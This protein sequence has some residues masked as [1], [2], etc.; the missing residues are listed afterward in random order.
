MIGLL[1]KIYNVYT[2]KIAKLRAF[3]WSTFLKKCGKNVYIK[4]GCKFF[5]PKGIEI[6]DHTLIGDNA[7]I[8]GKF[9]VKIGSFVSF[10]G[11]IDVFTVRNSYEDWHKPLCFQGYTGSPVEIGDDVWIGTKAVIMPGVKIGRGAIIGASA[12]VTKDV[13]SY[14]IVGGI[15]AKIIKF[16]FDKENISKANK[17]KF[18]SAKGRF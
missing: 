4:P 9:G 13:P 11:D 15:P 1:I 16:R 5:H 7:R 2:F 17:I 10:A 6:G 18:K 14:A 8:G 3:F 12:V